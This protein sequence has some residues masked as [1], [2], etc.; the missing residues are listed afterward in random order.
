MRK[1]LAIFFLSVYLFSTTEASE[2]LKFPMLVTHFIDHKVK[3]PEL[4]LFG[5]FFLHY[6]GDHFENHPVDVDFQEDH[7]L[8]F[9]AGAMFVSFCFVPPSHETAQGLL[10][11]PIIIREPEIPLDDPKGVF[12]YLSSIWQPPKSLV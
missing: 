6:H 9:M 8:P 10:P 2:L 12:Q 5:F 3:D 4:T 11:S 7:K 1:L